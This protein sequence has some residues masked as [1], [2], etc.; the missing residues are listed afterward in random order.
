MVNKQ[1]G[2]S[3]RARKKKVKSERTTIRFRPE[4]IDRVMLLLDL[5]AKLLGE[6][7]ELA[8]LFC[9]SGMRDVERQIR[10]LELIRA[11]RLAATAAAPALA[12]AG[13]PA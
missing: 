9:D 12:V 7:D 8:P 3:R 1:A 2:R 13:Q 4:Q 5:R 11:E 6:H 10:E